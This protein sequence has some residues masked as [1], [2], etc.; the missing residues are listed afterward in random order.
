[1]RV[2]GHNRNRPR[3]RCRAR[4]GAGRVDQ[5]HE[6]KKA[7]YD[8]AS[9]QSLRWE[10]ASAAREATAQALAAR[11]RDALESPE[12]KRLAERY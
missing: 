12:Q 4:S 1:M 6:R 3:A 10:L 7:G 2:L 11:M 9:M 8:P 5:S